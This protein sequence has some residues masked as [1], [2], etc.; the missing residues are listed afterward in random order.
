MNGDQGTA[1][2]NAFPNVPKKI[3]PFIRNNFSSHSLPP[4]NEDDRIRSDLRQV[5]ENRCIEEQVGDTP[6]LLGTRTLGPQDPRTETSP[7]RTLSEDRLHVSVRIGPLPVEPDSFDDL[8]S[9]PK[10]SGRLAAK[11]LGKRKPTSQPPTK[12]GP[13][14]PSQGI[15]IRRRRVA[16]SQS[17]PKRKLVQSAFDSASVAFNSA[18]GAFNTASGAFNSKLCCCIKQSNETVGTGGESFLRDENGSEAQ[19]PPSSI[20]TYRDSPLPD[21]EAQRRAVFD[22]A[23]MKLSESAGQDSNSTASLK[24]RREDEI[25][26]ERR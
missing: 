16:K 21:D 1:K 14:S 23:E 20:P 12:T 15:N 19:A 25:E 6:L 11:V 26:E 13:S 10:R 2:N 7:I 18:S 8:G 9:L 22:W 17:S 24:K 3:S 5:L 4:L